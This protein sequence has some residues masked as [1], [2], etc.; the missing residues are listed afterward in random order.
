MKTNSIHSIYSIR[1]IAYCC[2]H[3]G[4]VA[5]FPLINYAQPVGPNHFVTANDYDSNFK[6]G[7]TFNGISHDSS[8]YLTLSQGSTGIAIYDSSSYGG[9]SG[10]GGTDGDDY[11]DNME[12][13]SVSAWIGSSN[14][15]QAAFRA[16]YLLRMDNNESN[17]YLV[18]VTSLDSEN[19]AFEVYEGAG[20]TQTGS[21]IS[22]QVVS[23][24]T[25]TL[26]TDTLYAFKVSLVGGLF[27]MDFANGEATASYTDSSLSTMSGQVGIMLG[28][29]SP[30]VEIHL[31]TFTIVDKDGAPNPPSDISLTG[32]SVEENEA[33]V[34]DVGQFTSLDPDLSSTNFLYSLVSG[35]GDSGNDFFSI[36]GNTLQT[37]KS[38]N[39]EAASTYSIRV[40]S[41]DE[42]GEYREEVFEIAI[43]DQQESPLSIHEFYPVG[44]NHYIIKWSL[45]AGYSYQ[46]QKTATLQPE[47]WEDHH[48]P[49]VAEDGE[50]AVIFHLYTTTDETALF[51][52]VVRSELP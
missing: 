23:L 5:A 15:Y 42:A 51:F 19:V 45:D 2:I 20:L 41:T 10:S 9:S 17:G 4:C 40:R 30:I 31:D 28:R 24:N 22:Y 26:E 3:L 27:T 43:L 34:V 6:E 49:V 16:G 32:T 1:F 47:D 38:F 52:R 36:S 35:N 12:D 13:I 11:D 21:R 50:S 29:P 39:Y 18:Q 33:R 14:Y 25:L 8:G 7:A 46:V 44:L 37:N 48:E